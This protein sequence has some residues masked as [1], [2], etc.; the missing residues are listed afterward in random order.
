[1]EEQNHCTKSSKFHPE[2]KKFI[3]KFQVE[4][5]NYDTQDWINNSYISKSDLIKVYKYGDS[6]QTSP[7][8]KYGKPKVQERETSFDKN[9]GKK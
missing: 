3:M 7:T 2:S 1:M 8:K 5:D 4:S 9:Q 6:Q